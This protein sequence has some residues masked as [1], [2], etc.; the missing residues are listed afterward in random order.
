MLATNNEKHEILKIQ[1][2]RTS[3]NIK[4][5]EINLTRCLRH[6]QWKL[7]KLKETYIHGEIKD[8]GL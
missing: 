3:K 4:H 5:L 1:F 7:L 6:P 8:G 2:I